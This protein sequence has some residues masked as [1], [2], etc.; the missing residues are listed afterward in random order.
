MGTSLHKSFSAEVA[1]LANAATRL[2]DL[3]T[4][5]HPM[6]SITLSEGGILI[7]ASPSKGA[8]DLI[9]A[10]PSA[11]C[12]LAVSAVFTVRQP[13]DLV[14]LQ[15]PLSPHPLQSLPESSAPPCQRSISYRP[16]PLP[17]P[18]PHHFLPLPFPFP[19]NTFP[20]RPL[21]LPFRGT[22]ARTSIPT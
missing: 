2:L 4:V 18:L 17:L 15:S 12:T 22:K 6:G 9:R 10:S 3:V 21:P 8:A 20:P 1:S 13:S 16:L 5:L 7:R 11:G 14:Q 19:P